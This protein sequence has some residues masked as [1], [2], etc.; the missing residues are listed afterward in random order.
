MRIAVFGAGAIGCYVGGRLAAAGGDVVLIGRARI[1]AEIG[2]GLTL[3]DYRGGRGV[4]GPLPFA[5][6]P[7]AAAGAE[8]VLVCVKSQASVAA[9]ESLRPVLAPG[10]LVVSLQNGIGNA[11]VLAEGLGRPVLAG[12]VGFNVAAQGG[13]HFHQGTQ[14]DLHVTRDTRL[15][16]ALFAR[17]GLPLVLHDDMAPVLW[18]KLQF[19]LNNAINALSGLPLKEQLSDR[20]FRRCLALAH[21]ELIA[22]CAEAGQTLARLTPL[23][24]A[25]LPAVLRLPDPLFRLIAGG[26][27]KIDPLARSSM[28]DDL[29][30]G[31]APEL[32]AIN[33]EV[34]RLAARLGREAPVNDRLTALVHEAATTG[35]RWSGAALLAALD[36]D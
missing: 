11:G 28:A 10:A 9:A 32:A 27:L 24:A 18:A 5:E 21:G 30:R 12:M 31:R 26:M 3:T 29:A 13:G 23:P 15:P 16:L 33:G 4:T 8:L 2:G 34:A 14:G 20:A 35:R 36:P 7:E 22:L 19:N 1:G 25:W 17:A 6:T